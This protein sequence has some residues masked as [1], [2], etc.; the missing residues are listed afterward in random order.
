MPFAPST[1]NQEIYYEIQGQ[2]GPGPT[3]VFV[4][5]YMGIANIWQPLISS[6]RSRHHCIAYDSRGYGRS[7]KPETPDSYTVPGHAADLRA[8]LRAANITHPVVLITHSMGGNIASTYFLKHPDTV[9]GIIYTGTYYDGKTVDGKFITYDGLTDGVESPSRAARFYSAM[10]LS[11]DIALE[12]AKWPPHGR[13]Y[14]AKALFQCDMQDSYTYITV[15][16]LIVQGEHDLLP[17][18]HCVM[19]MARALP[20]CRLEI[21]P[22]VYHFPPTE[23]PEVLKGLVEGFLGGL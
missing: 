21:L 12:A 1:D 4:S 8:V 18:E 10:G 2:P 14:N 11:E 15:P 23:A 3:L 22:G 7:S 13:R 6:L 17:L 9:A 19:P 20:S 5:G 16:T